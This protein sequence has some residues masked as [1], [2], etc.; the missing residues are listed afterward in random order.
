M[1]KGSFLKAQCQP[2]LFL[3]NFIWETN[4]I[5]KTEVGSNDYHL[6]RPLKIYRAPLLTGTPLILPAIQ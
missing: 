2:C 4:C 3:K 5:L 1:W 6:S